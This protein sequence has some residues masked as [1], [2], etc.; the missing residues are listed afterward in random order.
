MGFLSMWQ[1]RQDGG[2]C[3]HLSWFG[4]LLLLMLA[5]AQRTSAGVLRSSESSSFEDFLE[6]KALK[7]SNEFPSIS[8]NDDIPINNQINSSGLVFSNMDF[9]FPNFP[10]G[11]KFEW[12]D[13]PTPPK[14]NWHDLPTPPKI[15]WHDLPTPPK[16]SWHDL[17]TPPMKNWPDFPT[18]DWNKAYEGD[19]V[20]TSTY[21]YSHGRMLF[22]PIG[23][24]LFLISV[25]IRV[26]ICNTRKPAP[27]TITVVRRTVVI[28][29]ESPD[30]EEGTDQPPSYADVQK[31]DSPPPYSEVSTPAASH[32]APEATEQPTTSN[33]EGG[34]DQ[35][36]TADT[37]SAPEGTLATNVFSGR[38]KFLQ[39]QYSYK[40]LE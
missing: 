4:C 1:N 36:S 15:N 9:N 20:N 37:P 24:I 14:I 28:P 32:T 6:F 33:V 39:S 11:P 17:P 13:I 22:I 8:N 10:T 35:T 18:P 27:T 2:W 19:S 31:E 12:R 25:C 38:P 21:G 26:C 23:A 5:L 34:A 16:I 7:D 29:V 30:V 3:L 40:P